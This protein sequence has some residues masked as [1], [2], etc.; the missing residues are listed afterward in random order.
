MA[1]QTGLRLYATK[2]EKL[3]ESEGT[4]LVDAYDTDQK[5]ADVARC[6]RILNGYEAPELAL[7]TT[8]APAKGK[9]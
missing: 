1:L 8:G 6:L 3:K 5:L 9:A 7:A 4:L 2:R